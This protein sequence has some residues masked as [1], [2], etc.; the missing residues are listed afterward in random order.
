MKTK[1][2]LLGAGTLTQ[3]AIVSLLVLTLLGSV[4]IPALE[5]QRS[6]RLLREISDE[7]EPARLLS[8][9]L[10][11][12]LAMEYSELQ[13]YA[14]SGDSVQ[15]RHYR[16]ITEAEARDLASLERLA[17]HLGPGSMDELAV[18]RQ[19]IASWQTLNR[20]LFEGTVTSRQFTIA[21]NNQRALRDSIIVELDRLPARLT[22]AA[23]TRRAE[24]RTHEQRSLFVN[25]VLVCVALVASGAVVALSR[26]ERRLAAL[27]RNRFEEE[28][29]MRQMARELSEA[30]TI[31]EA[32]HRIVEGTTATLPGFGAYVEFAPSNDDAVR[33]AALLAGGTA[34]PSS[35][36]RSRAG[37]LTDDAVRAA[38]TQVTQMDAVERRLPPDLALTLP[39]CTA[40]VAPLLSSGVPF[41]VLVLLR[42]AESAPFSEDARTRMELLGDLAAAVLRRVEA[43]RG[44]L[45]GAQKRA[46]YETTL[47]KAAEALAEAFSVDEVTEQIMRSALTAIKARGAYIKHIVSSDDM[48]VVVVRGATGE[49]VP[50]L[51]TTREYAGS[52]TQRAIVAGGPLLVDDPGANAASTES[53]ARDDAGSTIVLPLGSEDARIGA[54]FI[55][56]AAPVRYASDDVTWAVT[57]GHLAALAYEKVRLIEEARE[58]RRELERVMRSRQRLIRG[59][60]H[61]VKNPLGA[62]DG[63]AEL[64]SLGL[65][66]DLSDEQKSSIARMRRS[67]GGALALIDELH[68]LSRVETGNLALRRDTVDL[69]ELARASGEEYRGAAMAN[70]L[71]LHVDVPHDTPIVQSDAARIRQIVGN[72]LSN[73]IKYTR[74][75]SITLRV[76]T[77]HSVTTD[78]AGDWVYFDVIDTGI[79][80]P[81]DK[82]E[83]IFEEFSRLNAHDK[84][85]AGLGLAISERLARALG[86]QIVVRSEVGHGST[87]TL[88]IPTRASDGAADTPERTSTRA[89]VSLTQALTIPALPPAPPQSQS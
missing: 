16:L 74:T 52:Y 23:V 60:S 44:A 9:R 6:L 25:A 55:V 38:S 39:S 34:K 88:R 72:L 82:R 47:R 62:A 87:F 43:E 59:F 64:L 32:M 8:W 36:R 57:F 63:Y 22:A 86:G 13:G 29:A 7:I 56:G 67:I 31:D 12:G 69:G 5:T 50:A 65:F 80:I 51:R 70:G 68:D 27:L 83:T 30:V 79:G 75:G 54:L 53:A 42:T 58:G 33:A 2:Q 37:S 14:L 28:A 76:R 19:R 73:A 71:A 18:I 35:A 20:A 40:L 41:G 21:A 84:P 66:G 81:E 26:R 48:D 61:D 46:T 17:P 45:A 15:L 11:S 10:E 85:G 24:V 3:L 1:Q 89:H 78:S 77:H 4:I 49:G